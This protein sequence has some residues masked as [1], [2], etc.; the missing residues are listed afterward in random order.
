MESTGRSDPD[1]QTIAVRIDEVDFT[2]PRLIHDIYPNSCATASMS[3]TRR[4]RRVSGLASPLCSERKKTRRTASSYR[5]EHRQARF[6]C[7][8][9]LLLIAKPGEPGQSPAGV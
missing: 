5:R 7:V 1:P 6:K 8:L 4:W 2:T 9:P 3:S